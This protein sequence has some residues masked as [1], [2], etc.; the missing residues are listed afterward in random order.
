MRPARIFLIRHGET[1]WTLTGQHTGTTDIPLTD[2]GRTVAAGLGPVLAGIDF[3]LVLTSPMLRARETCE[4]AGFG[5]RCEIERELME[6]N[7]G[8]YEGLTSAEIKARTPGWSLFTDGCPGG[9]TPAQVGA[10]A[11]RVI[12]RLRGLQK[13][14]ALFGHGHI[15]RV[16]AV[17]WLGLPVSAGSHFLLDPG[18]VSV[19]SY[20]QESPAVKRWN[21]RV[22]DGP[23]AWHD[24][25][26]NE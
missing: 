17:R 2:H 24:M 25:W 4:L 8:D 18:T 1:T 13:D 7:Y 21:V 12:A 6:W 10:R 23:G 15:F 11:D 9:E 3:G 19:V 5:G 22:V 20:Y 16:F 26:R 14:A